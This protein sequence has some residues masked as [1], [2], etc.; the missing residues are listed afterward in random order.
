M[1]ELMVSTNLRMA[2]GVGLLELP[3]ITQSLCL[4]HFYV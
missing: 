2:D 3:Q 4:D 1:V